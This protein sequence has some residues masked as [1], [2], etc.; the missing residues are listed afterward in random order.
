ML[1]SQCGRA[2]SF[3]LRKLVFAAFTFA[4]VGLMALPATAQTLTVLHIFTSEAGGPFLTLAQYSSA[5]ISMARP[6][7]VARTTRGPRSS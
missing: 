4:G 5:A 2:S 1:I 3:A 6:T 7:R